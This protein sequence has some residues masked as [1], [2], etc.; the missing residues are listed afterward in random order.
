MFLK[1]VHQLDDCFYST[2]QFIMSWSFAISASFLSFSLTSKSP[3]RFHPCCFLA[4]NSRFVSS[5]TY[6]STIAVD[7]L[8]AS[9]VSS[10]SWFWDC[11]CLAA[12]VWMRGHSVPRPPESFASPNATTHRL[13]NARPINDIFHLW[14]EYQTQGQLYYQPLFWIPPEASVSPI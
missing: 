12:D 3:K 13:E 10:S 7:L 4:Q 6:N 8:V 11:I 9:P 1:T 2:G 5:S 14:P